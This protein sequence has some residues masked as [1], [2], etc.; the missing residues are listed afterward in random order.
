MSRAAAVLTLEQSKLGVSLPRGT[1]EATGRPNARGPSCGS[2][3][4]AAVINTN[5]P[6][7]DFQNAIPP[8]PALVIGE[9]ESLD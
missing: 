5:A 7:A 4:D 1:N 8:L 6:K 3:G 9:L 2:A